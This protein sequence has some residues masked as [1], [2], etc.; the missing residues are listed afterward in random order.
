MQLIPPGEHTELVGDVQAQ[1]QPGVTYRAQWEALVGPADR[2]SSTADLDV[3][4]DPRA[5]AAT[6]RSLRDRGSTRS[7]ARSSPTLRLDDPS[8]RHCSHCEES[9]RIEPAR[10]SKALWRP[11]SP[12]TTPNRTS[13]KPSNPLESYELIEMVIGPRTPQLGRFVGDIPWPRGCVL[14]ALSEGSEIF[15][16]RGDTELREG[17]RVILLAPITEGTPTP[18]R[19]DAPS[20]DN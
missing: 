15:A 18:Q 7:F 10:P 12:L 9:Q 11:S 5:G 13:T 8:G 19:A 2:H 14:L 1:A 3:Q 16:P 20:C 17:E 4:R 6:T